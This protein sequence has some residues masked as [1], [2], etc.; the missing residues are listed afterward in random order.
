MESEYRAARLTEFAAQP[1]I[2][3]FMLKRTFGAGAVAALLA[4]LHAGAAAATTIGAA[5]RAAVPEPS[6]LVL[7]G[8]GVALLGAAMLLRRRSG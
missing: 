5:A 2:G 6:T 4:P 8:F 3:V 1:R 7:F